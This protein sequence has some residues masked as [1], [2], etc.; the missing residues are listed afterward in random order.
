M[1]LKK[2]ISPACLMLL[3]FASC[4]SGY[5]DVNDDPNSPTK[6]ELK[7][8]LTGAQVEVGKSFAPG[9]YIGTSLPSYIFHLTS[10]E[11]DNF[12]LSASYSTLGNTWLQSYAYGLK[13]TNAVINEAEATN[14]WI[15]AGI[16]K[17]M[18]AY[19]FANVVDLWGDVPYSESNVEN[20]YKPKLD[21]SKDIYNSLF[22]LI[23]DALTDLNKTEGNLLTPASDDLFYG[24]NKAKWI[25]MGNTLKLKLLLQ[26]RKAQS[27]ITGWSEKLSSVLAANNFILNGED[28]EFK[29]TSKDNPD[30]RNGAFVDEYG[31]GQSTYYINP[32]L[33]ETMSGMTL[34]VT[35]NPFANIS[36]PRIPY[37]WVNQIKSDAT[38]QNNTD[39]RDGAFVS[40]F[41]ASNSSASGSDQRNTSTFIGIYPCGGK[42]DD[43]S[44]GKVGIDSGTGVAP[45]KMLQAYSVPFMLAELY[46]TGAATGDARAALKMGIERSITHVNTVSQAAKLGSATVP[47]IRITDA[48]VIDF[49]NKVLAVYDG[50]S[51]N[52]EKLR[53]VMTQKWIANFFNSIEA[54]SDIRRTGYPTLLASNVSF[55]LSP[56]KSSKEPEQ[57]VTEIPLKGVNAFPRAMWYP[58]SEVTRNPNVTNSGRNL[59]TPLVF[60]DK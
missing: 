33:Y 30:E 4:T 39:Y 26:S 9:S 12:G 2:I 51:S 37:Y 11:V 16:G 54:Y 58:T 23:D 27:D 5:L 35:N 53:V 21:S 24:G 14:N 3:L 48:N 50:A 47:V 20:N 8:V 45:E 32:W 43:G 57:G 19:L 6:A 34:N 60:W 49:I 38:A 22:D 28:F 42:Y 29:H 7:K 41:F 17:L 52:E 59:S 46:L 15:Y 36:D 40:L 13:N 1:K 56:Y 31:G 55:A 25:K 18:K 10:R 44:A